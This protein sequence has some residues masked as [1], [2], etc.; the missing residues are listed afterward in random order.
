MKK[1][2]I[3][4]LVL[5]ILA[6]ATNVYN[7]KFNVLGSSPTDKGS[8][9]LVTHIS[10]NNESINSTNYYDESGKNNHGSGTNMTKADST[11]GIIKQAGDFNGTNETIT[12]SN[13]VD[14][15]NPFTV[16]AWIKTTDN[17]GT[18]NV[19]SQVSD[20][21]PYVIG[22]FFLRV[23]NGTLQ[24]FRR[25]G[26]SDAG[27]LWAYSS[28]AP[29]G[30]WI[31][32]MAVYNG[33]DTNADLYINGVKESPVAGAGSV[34]GLQDVVV[35]GAL[36]TSLTYFKGL[37]DEV[38]IYN[39]ALSESEVIGIYNATNVNYIDG[40]I[41]NDNLILHYNMD[42]EDL[43]GVNVYDNSGNNYH[44]VSNAA[45]ST[46]Y[47]KYKDS[48]NFN[49]T[50]DYIAVPDNLKWDFLNDS[51]T[52]AFWYRDN[53]TASSYPG[54]FI[55]SYST[56]FPALLISGNGGTMQVFATSNGLTWNIIN[57]MN[58]GSHSNT[59]FHHYILTRNGITFKTY[60]DGVFVATVSNTGVLQV[61]VGSPQIGRYF[62]GRYLKGWLDDYRVYKRGISAAEAAQMYNYSKKRVIDTNLGST[63]IK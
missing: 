51:F 14:G 16:S 40:D 59:E 8:G 10:L 31:H 19:I 61:Q 7:K 11:T 15:V 25:H 3:P 13:R 36:G 54:L 30:Q 26:T 6:F 43:L 52:V 32:V 35:I 53:D 28:I 57:N 24:F 23:L 34:G 38:R 41:S 58:L 18:Y 33:S 22:D 4:I 27:K 48:L 47:G 60:K 37:I 50:S 42:R 62:D 39:Y 21:T 63:V 2:I 12:L 1:I 49:G 56:Y 55:R 44:G 29:T 17:G 46:A 45:Q 9:T 20:G 5:G